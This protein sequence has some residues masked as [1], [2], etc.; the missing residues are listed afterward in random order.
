MEP[1]SVVVTLVYVTD[2]VGVA[3]SIAVTSISIAAPPHCSS[4]SVRACSTWTTNRHGSDAWIQ[5]R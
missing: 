2:G 5:E 4:A 1:K 3:T